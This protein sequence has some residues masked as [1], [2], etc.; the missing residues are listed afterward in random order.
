MAVATVV[1]AGAARVVEHNALVFK[2][3][4]RGSMTVS[5]FTPLFF[6]ASMGLGLGSLVNKSSGG[7][8]GVPY[9][10]FLAPGL[11]AATTMQTAAFECTYPIL[12]KILWDHIYDAMLA[13]PPS[14][15]PQ[16][17]VLLGYAHFFLLLGVVLVG[18]VVAGVIRQIQPASGQSAVAA[19]PHIGEGGL[20][21]FQVDSNWPK[22]P[23]KW[24]MGFGSAVTADDQARFFLRI[25]RLVPARHRDYAMGLLRGIVPAQ[26]WGIAATVP[27]GWE[28]AF[29]GGWGRGV[30]RQVD[31]QAALLTNSGLRVS[32]AV[33]TG[34]NPSDGYGTAT[35]RGV[36]A[37]L[38]R[39]LDGRV[40][41]T[42]VRSREGL[43]SDLA[44]EHQT[45]HSLSSRPTYMLDCKI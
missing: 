17:A 41:G 27:E 42:V 25:D 8:G 24:K 30:T 40:L 9:I 2:R 34:S 14:Q 6:I 20:P 7:V 43:G 15:R 32:V 33:L 28:I 16:R 10:D 45:A 36:A 31:H 3:M 44:I 29:K 22:L 38:L 13:T 39:G 12:G 23:A 1:P 26:R 4:W 35:I 11:L 37:R 21:Q 18:L 5:F 19:A